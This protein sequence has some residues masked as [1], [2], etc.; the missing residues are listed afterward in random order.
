MT[1]RQKELLRILVDEYI[2]RMPDD[3]ART[4]SA[5]LNADLDKLR[6]AWIGAIRA[7]DAPKP[8][9]SFGCT[10]GDTRWECLP[11]GFPYYYRVQ[12]PTFLIEYMSTNG[13][14]SH[15]VWRD[16]HDGDFGEDL[17]RAHYADVPHAGVPARTLLAAR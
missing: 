3:I 13:N 15:S 1:P 7:E 12:G 4:R 17:L 2:S 5:A 10:A 16:F 11:I 9:A 14:H 6:F 8:T